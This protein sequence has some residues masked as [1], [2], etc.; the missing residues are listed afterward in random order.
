[1]Q[2]FSKSKCPNISKLM[3]PKKFQIVGYKNTSTPGCNLSLC[4]IN[5][6]RKMVHI[7]MTAMTSRIARI[8]DC[9]TAVV[10]TAYRLKNIMALVTSLR[11]RFPHMRIII[12]DEKDSQKTPDFEQLLRT[13]SNVTYVNGPHGIANGRNVA[14][15]LVTTKYFLLLDD[16]YIFTKRT[17]IRKML[18]LLEASDVSVVGGSVGGAGF[19]GVHRVYVDKDGKQHLVQYTS[20]A[21]EVV[22][23]FQS[24]VIVDIVKN[25][26]LARTRDVSKA[27]AWNDKYIVAEHKDFFLK[28][29]LSRFKIAFCPD[30]DVK[31]YSVEGM[32]LA[33]ARM[34]IVDKYLSMFNSDWQIYKIHMCDKTRYFEN[35][36]C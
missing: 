9:V 23:C 5:K 13:D 25:F 12:T 28:M 14:I 6:G 11:A 15:K 32:A 22:P 36:M 21:Y 27:G 34:Q 10:K 33:N 19:E 24:C 1:M 17:N 20:V 8:S 16:D 18:D 2:N 7:N 29:R 4:S 35:N 30:V 31:H 3:A 26:F